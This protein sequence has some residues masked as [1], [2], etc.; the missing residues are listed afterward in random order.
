MGAIEIVLC[1]IITRHGDN[2]LARRI[3]NGKIRSIITRD[4]VGSVYYIAK[5]IH[6]D[7]AVEPKCLFCAKGSWKG[8]R[9]LWIKEIS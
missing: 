4:D 2:T 1:T 7:S 9:Y 3:S 5:N 8:K 6:N